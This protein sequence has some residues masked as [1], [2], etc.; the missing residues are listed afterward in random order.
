MS[1]NGTINI[2]INSNNQLLDM[3]CWLRDSRIEAV[4]SDAIFNS[5]TVKS[6]INCFIADEKERTLFILRWGN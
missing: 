5:G 6:S 4:F 2:A 3:Y 1:R